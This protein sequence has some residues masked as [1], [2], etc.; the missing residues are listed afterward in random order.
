VQ[1]Y[2]L[3]QSADVIRSTM[4]HGR[5]KYI[6]SIVG[7]ER[8]Q[9]EGWREYGGNKCYFLGSESIQYRSRYNVGNKKHYMLAVPC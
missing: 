8:N 1:L 6:I 5:D 3:I 9:E 4:M 2:H 7:G